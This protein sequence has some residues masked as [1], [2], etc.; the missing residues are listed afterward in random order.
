MSTIRS[1]LNTR[2][3]GRRALVAFG[4]ALLVIAGLLA[5]H[6]IGAGAVHAEAGVP[7]TV[8]MGDEADDAKHCPG[9]CA[10]GDAPDHS[11]LLM[12]CALALLAAA[13]VLLAPSLLGRRRIPSRSVLLHEAVRALPWPQP[14]S[15]HVLSISRT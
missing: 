6:T 7:V 8:V 3:S 2:S 4:G 12:I 11:M 1:L 9:D 15:L 13:L 5:M 14:P 10:P